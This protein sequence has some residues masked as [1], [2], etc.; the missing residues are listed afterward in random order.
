MR[1]PRGIASVGSTTACRDRHNFLEPSPSDTHLNCASS[2]AMPSAPGEPP[3]FGWIYRL[4][5]SMRQKM[6]KTLNDYDYFCKTNVV[7]GVA[8]EA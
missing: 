3:K 7:T 6:I 1:G 5:K 2:N 4:I 8:K